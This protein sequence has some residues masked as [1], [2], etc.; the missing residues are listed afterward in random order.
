[1]LTA[2][3]DEMIQVAL[4]SLN[5]IFKAAKTHGK[6]NI[7]DTLYQIVNI[8]HGCGG[9][10]V[11]MNLKMHASHQISSRASHM[12]SDGEVSRI[13]LTLDAIVSTGTE[14]E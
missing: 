10:P 1:M 5:N 6:S 14:Y 9:I 4:E 8:F 13:L 7:D 2:H 11:I 12:S 3:N